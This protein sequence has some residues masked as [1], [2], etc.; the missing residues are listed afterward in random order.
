MCVDLELFKYWSLKGEKNAEHWSFFVLAPNKNINLAENIDIN[1]ETIK[2]N[3]ITETFLLNFTT[4][5]S[6]IGRFHAVGGKSD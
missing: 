2:K 3:Q 4:E 1:H 5:E 6:I